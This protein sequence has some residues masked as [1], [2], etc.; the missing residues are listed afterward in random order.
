[1][2]GGMQD[3]NY[4]A[5]GC[6]EITLELSCC[7]YPAASELE[8]AWT[9]N[10]KSLIEYLKMANTGIKGI[11]TYS[12]GSPAKHLSIQIDSREPIFKTNEFGEYYRILAPGSYKM[13]IMY[14]CDTVMTVRVSVNSGSGTIMPTIRLDPLRSQRSSSYRLDK[15]PIFCKRS[16]APTC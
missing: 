7:K 4:W 12:D 14:S 8:K 9:D 1:L 6:M 16:G 5:N 13:S 10:K 15:N 2:A 3:Y 11:I